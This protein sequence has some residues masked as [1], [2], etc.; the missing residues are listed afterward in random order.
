MI[1]MNDVKVEQGIAQERYQVI[2]DSRRA[3]RSKE[4]NQQRVAVH[5]R[6]LNWLGRQ[7]GKL[8]AGWEPGR[9][10]AGEQVV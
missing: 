9:D 5:K 1:N 10:T 4:G 2:I 8:G 6:A 3:R 7:A